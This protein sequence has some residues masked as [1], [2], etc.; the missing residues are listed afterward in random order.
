MQQVL[1]QTIFE[2][3]AIGSATPRVHS[4]SN[5]SIGETGVGAAARAMRQV[6][7]RAICAPFTPAGTAGT[8]DLSRGSRRWPPLLSHATGLLTASPAPMHLFQHIPCSTS[9]PAG[10]GHDVLSARDGRMNGVPTA[11]LPNSASTALPRGPANVFQTEQRAGRWEWVKRRNE[12]RALA[13]GRGKYVGK[14]C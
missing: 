13:L 10:N 4:G 2:S 7:A 11:P 6:G 12:E 9:L 14:G 1:G 5:L 3:S 8:S